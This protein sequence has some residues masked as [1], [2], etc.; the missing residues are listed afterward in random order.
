MTEFDQVENWIEQILISANVS[1]GSLAYWKLL[2]SLTLLAIIA[3]VVFFVT[4]KVIINYI[5]KL[6]RKSPITWDDILADHQVFNNVAHFVPALFVRSLAPSIFADFPDI[7]PFVIKLTDVYLIIVGMTVFFAL[8]KVAEFALTRHPAFK[9]KPLTS[10]FQLI[11]IILYIGTGIFVLSI[12]LG[13]SPLYFLSAFGAMTA[14][15]LLIFKDTILGLVASVQMSSN[16]MVRV[17][18]WVEMPKFNADGDVVAIN[19]NTVKVQNWDR[20][21]TTIPTYYFITDSFKNWRGMVESGGRRIKRSIHINS[22]SIKFVDPEKREIFKKFNL[23]T[24]YVSSRQEEIDKHN[25]DNQI[26]TSI[27][28]NGRRMTNI[29]VFRKYVESYL[30][31]HPKIKKNMT[32]MVRQLAIED[33]GIPIEIYCFT[34]TTAWLEYESIQADIFDHLLAAAAYFDLEIFQVP[35]GK[36]IIQAANAYNSYR[37]SE[38]PSLNI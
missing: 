24:N 34:D 11:R 13:K 4:K 15:L 3:I 33:R 16:D 5:Y 27:L 20:T 22:H 2:I 29:G 23:L 1:T 18:D 25:Q 26:D 37:S 14:I 17:G 12:L 9:D 38:N 19:L 28:I 35:S 10:Y 7:L 6:V 8:L 32:I 36:D 21:I 31:N 30:Q